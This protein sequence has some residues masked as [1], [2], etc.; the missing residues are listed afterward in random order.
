MAIPHAACRRPATTED[1]AA[2]CCRRPDAIAEAGDGS[3]RSGLRITI[4]MHDIFFDPTELSIPAD[5][6]SRGS[7]W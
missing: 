1:E 4:T 2:G 3:R 6:R 7:T 5:T